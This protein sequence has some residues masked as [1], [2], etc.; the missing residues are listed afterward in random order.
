MTRHTNARTHKSVYVR[1]CVSAC[2]SAVDPIV[3]DEEEA[4]G[5]LKRDIS[6]LG[7]RYVYDRSIE[8]T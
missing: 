6:F 4:Q 7:C 1:T 3:K 5:F 8:H 2:L